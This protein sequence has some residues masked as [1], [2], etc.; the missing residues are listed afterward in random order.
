VMNAPSGPVE[1]GPGPDPGNPILELGY[2]IL[3]NVYLKP[4][5]KVWNEIKDHDSISVQQIIHVIMAHTNG[6]QDS[7]DQRDLFNDY[8]TLEMK[9]AIIY[10]YL[11]TNFIPLENGAMRGKLRKI[12]EDVFLGVGISTL[13]NLCLA[14]QCFQMIIRRDPNIYPEDRADG[15]EQQRTARLET[16]LLET[17]SR[18]VDHV[19]IK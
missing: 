6:I 18:I 7:E 17:I 5:E 4:A 1:L 11:L 8:K 9:V 19:Y 14:R 12:Q 10:G 2:K 15:P 16:K 13:P 3:E